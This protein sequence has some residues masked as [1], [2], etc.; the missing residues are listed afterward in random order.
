MP[1]LYPT[2]AV[3]L[4][5]LL[6][7]RPSTWPSLFFLGTGTEYASHRLFGFDMSIVTINCVYNLIETLLIALVLRRFADLKTWYLSLRWVAVCTLGSLVVAS[8]AVMVCLGLILLVGHPASDRIVTL[9]RWFEQ[10]ISDT[11]SIALIT[12]I[13]LSWTE[14]G[15]RHSARP[16]AVLEGV[17]LMSAVAALTYAAFL[18]SD[19]V[20]ALFLM[21]PLLS[22]VTLRAGLVGATAGAVVGTAVAIWATVRGWGPIATQPNL[23]LGDRISFMQLYFLGASLSSIPMAMILK[24][25]TTLAEAVDAQA[26]ISQA[27]LS[28]MAQGLSMF[29]AQDRLIIC[30]GEYSRLYALPERLT[31]P[32][33]SL[34]QMVDHLPL[35]GKPM[36]KLKRL[37]RKVRAS[38]DQDSIGEIALSDGRVINVHCRILADGGW[39]ATHEDITERRKAEERIAYLAN[40]DALTG[41]S[42]RAQFN[43]QLN[44][45]V[46]YLGRGHRFALHAVDLDRFK[47]VNDTLGHAA[48]DE[49]LRQVA[50]RLRDAVRTGEVV[51]RIGGDEFAILQFPLESAE[52]ASALAARV[53]K[54]LAKPFTIDGRKVQIGASV[55]IA[56]APDDTCD[57]AELMQKSDLALYRAKMD[58]RNAYRFYQR[59]MDAA[60]HARRSLEADLRAA[61]G[62]DEFV[63]HYQPIVD[64]AEGR[65]VSC[66]A[67]V[68]WLH[69]ER[70]LIDPGGFITVAEETGL[71]LPIGQ[72]VLNEACRQAASWLEGVK[73]A[74]NLSPVQFKNPRLVAQVKSALTRAGLDAS[75][76]ELE[77]TESVLLQNSKS[78]LRSLHRLRA[79]GVSI[80][81]DDFG[82]GYSSL[83][84]L[85]SFP[86]DKIKIDRS[87]ISQLG[88]RAENLAIVHSAI[89][90]SRSLGMICTGEGV[91]RAEEYALLEAEGCDQIQG[92]YISRPVP[93]NDVP[94]L[95]RRPP[96]ARGQRMKQVA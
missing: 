12:P 42:N 16:G 35:R 38:P 84:Y 93:A 10:T 75:R 9:P 4:V 54:L 26:A 20:A 39:V 40:F 6:R 8:L 48:G 24:V 79:M 2:T 15:F 91:E 23:A 68:R 58:G 82:T 67:L 30:N 63:L 36:A 33:T 7:N 17:G 86:F 73:V 56:V 95:L 51:T 49:L 50:S 44:R 85:R 47:E 5:T 64:V 59:G 11:A 87:F 53:V 3:M 69:P 43:E 71:I 37:I 88:S 78:V 45:F 89:G 31:E 22:L 27:A 19:S 94:L 81:M 60:Q 28:N 76:L 1:K 72:W 13:F 90:L 74:V 32:M 77:I 25:R 65:V 52:E 21:F 80:A 83:S 46:A 70:G 34:D 57:G 66:E 14:P 61:V 29:D 62:N 18:M 41:L 55:G 96:I 92:Y